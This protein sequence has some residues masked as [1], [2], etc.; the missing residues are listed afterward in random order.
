M[1]NF[2][3]TYP[4]K[5][6]S[7]DL[8]SLALLRVTL[9]VILLA[10]GINRVSNFTAFHSERG[11]FPREALLELYGSPYIWSLNH[12]AT[13]D[14]WQATI[15]VIYF[16][17]G[18]SLLIGFR[19]RTFTFV[20]WILQLSLQAR[21]PITMQGGDV[22]LRNMLFWGT[23]LPWGGTF[24]IDALKF[25]NKTSATVLSY[26]TIGICLQTIY[27][28]CFSVFLKNGPHW[29]VD[30]SAAYY[31]LNL[32]HFS[33]AYGKLVLS[34]PF[35]VL[36]F[37]TFA[38]L[39]WEL[40]APLMFL[41]PIGRHILRPMVILGF[42]FMHANFGG[43]LAIGDFFWI[44]ISCTMPFIPSESWDW[45]TQKAKPHF[46][47]F[48]NFAEILPS[49]LRRKLMERAS[50]PFFVLKDVESLFLSLVIVVVFL[51]NIESIP[52]SYLRPDP[53]RG[54]FSLLFR[55]DQRWDMFAPFPMTDDGWYVIRSTLRNGKEVDLFKDGMPVSYEKPES[56]KDT[57]KDFRWRKYMVNLWSASFNQY[58]KYFA[59]YLCRT[60]NESHP[61]DENVVNFEIIYMKEDTPPPGQPLPKAE[62]VPIFNWNC[63][64]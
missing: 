36:R 1:R 62:K 29:R 49:F 8:R 35:E 43:A 34:L 58:R 33:T 28:Y 10:D 60:W 16:I 50:N 64:G 18:F 44:S 27:L 56:V 37:F 23:F 55:F 24:S 45:L 17:A 9:A 6:F 38:V 22:L 30:G 32:D 46:T 47:A 41:V 25:K 4:E 14:W 12:L 3:K 54:N 15:L 52:G 59:R 61:S 31:A 39:L 26:A 53:Y 5:I 7:C 2:L 48:S 51:T 20:C 11:L 42:W 21:N 13:G 19:T 63:F 40:I 57:Y